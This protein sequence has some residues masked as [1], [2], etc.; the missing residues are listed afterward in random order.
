MQIFTD[1]D[2]ILIDLMIL[3]WEHDGK[4]MI[5]SDLD[6][7]LDQWILTSI[8]FPQFKLPASRAQQRAT[9]DS[10]ELN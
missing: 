1:L 7:I 9:N 8:F 10:V 3:W 2:R 5:F 6:R 4:G